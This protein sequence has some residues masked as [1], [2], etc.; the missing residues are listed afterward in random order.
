MAENL[1]GDE[2]SVATPWA[3]GIVDRSWYTSETLAPYRRPGNVRLPFGLTPVRVYQGAAWYQRDI[4]IPSGWRGKKI[5]LALERVHWESRLWLDSTEVGM[6][7]SLSTPHE[8]DLTRWLRGGRHTLTLLIDNRIRDIDIGRNAHSITD[9]TQTNWNGVVGRIEL[10]AEP[11][12]NIGDVRIDPDVSGKAIR[13]RTTVNGGVPESAGRWVLGLRVVTDMPPHR[14]K[15]HAVSIDVHAQ[16]G[17]QDID[18]TIALGPDAE[19]WD[20]FRPACYRLEVRVSGPRGQSLMRSLL[21]GLRSFRARGSRFSVNGHPTFLRGT[22]DCCM[23]PL[24][25]Y[26][27]T[28]VEEWQKILRAMKDYGIN[29]VRY[30]S[31]CPPE[32]AFVAADRLGMYLQ[33]ECA[34]WTRVGDGKP[35]DRWLYEES[36]RIVRAYGNHP[37]FCM[38]ASGNEPSGPNMNAFLAGFVKYWKGKDERRV[39]TSAAGWPQLPG[40]D[41]QSTMYPRIQVWGAGLESIINRAAPQTV[42]DFRDTVGKESMPVVAHETGQWCA[43]PNL[44]EIPKYTGVLRAGNY[45]IVRDA[46]KSRGMLGLAEKFLLASGKL[47]TLCY[48][49][50]VE[51][52]LRTPG[53]AGFQLLGLHDFPGQGTATVGVLDVFSEGKGYVTGKEFRR[54]CGATVPLV[55][56]KSFVFDRSD[57]LVADVEVAHF[58]SS[59]LTGVTPSWRIT[60]AGGKTAARGLLG[61]RDIE[62]DNCQLLGRI[63]VPLARVEAPH[64]FTLTVTVG[65][66]KNDWDF[67]VYPSPVSMPAS[68]SVMVTGVLDSGAVAGLE[69]GA[70][71]L[72]SLGR[73]RV[74]EGWG[75][76]VALGFSSIFWNTAWTSGQAPHTL[77]ILCKPTHPALA[78]FP[79]EYHSNFQWWDLV[80]RGS[81]L[82]L[83][84]LRLSGEPIVRIIDD[85]N[86]NRNLALVCEARAGKG[87]LV[88]CGAD[89]LTDLEHR[90]AARQMRKSLE[91]YMRGPRFNPATEVGVARLKKM[92]AGGSR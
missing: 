54:F 75:G 10:R 44:R 91:E 24:T 69:S 79:T 80:A 33:I 35:V 87:K 25:G 30:H 16:A 92:I 63:T 62:L 56:M 86:K 47:Q 85:W 38:M 46:M 5:V 8:Y 12:V 7:N 60:A 3:G 1:K 27:S 31:W 28:R 49:A 22:L 21:F 45:E 57:T 90:P 17:R 55:R 52:A 4:T 89:I 9:H 68:S 51:A 37:S 78:H 18:T 36:E 39:Y 48:K 82:N 76:E 81:A 32:A 26:P 42:F 14:Q 58:G 43:F 59:R 29:H 53:M 84:S 23:F 67:W 41:Y 66:A 19:L 20:E 77:G 71:V 13:I 74:A 2:V 73:G 11:A 15:G 64:K 70:T 34:L 50:D 6:Q 72:L 61:V 88:V 65:D 83:D 40:N